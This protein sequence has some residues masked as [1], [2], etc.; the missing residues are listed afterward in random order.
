[1]GK[2]LKT[3]LFATIVCVVCSLLL[4]GSY[5]ALK[6]R[7]DANKAVDFKSKVLQVFGV[8]VRDAKGHRLMSDQE[9]TDLFAKR[10]VGHVLDFDG[11]MTDKRVEDLSPEQINARDRSR[12]GLKA[13]YPYYEFTT[14]D[15]HKLYAIHVSG[16]GL[17]SVCKAYLALQ[18]D[19]STIAGVAFY[20]HAETPG[21]GG[22]IEKPAFQDQ[23]KGKRL[24]KEGVATYFRVL[25]P[26]EGLDDSAVHGPS[27]A[28]MTSKGITA[29]V[30]SDFSVYNKYF[31]T[32]KQ[33]G[34]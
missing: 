11:K 20:E 32:L 25:R 24:A 6:G 34:G 12:G 30:N 18:D 17:W 5:S 1:M 14:D 23:F 22:E 8:Q 15:G 28:T 2:E 16:M 9:V 21:L 29:F 13:F 33:Q 4:A 19:F 3:I 31:T 27:G 7:Q 26:S 10:V